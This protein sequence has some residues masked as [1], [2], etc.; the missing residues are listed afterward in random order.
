MIQ[1]VKLWKGV[2]KNQLVDISGQQWSRYGS[3]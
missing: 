2:T 1:N 3:V